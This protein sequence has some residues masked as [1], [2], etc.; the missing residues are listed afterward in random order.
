[1]LNNPLRYTDPSGFCDEEDHD[2]NCGVSFELTVTASSLL[3][4]KPPELPPR[5]EVAVEIPEYGTDDFSISFIWALV[6]FQTADGRSL[7]GVGTFRTSGGQTSATNTDAGENGSQNQSQGETTGGQVVGGG[8]AA[9]SQSLAALAATASAANRKAPTFEKDRFN[10][11]PSKARAIGTFGLSL[12]AEYAANNLEPGP[13]RGLA[14]T[15]AAGFAI[16]SMIETGI[17][18]GVSFLSIPPAIQSGIGALGVTSL[19]G[20]GGFF[21]Y[22]SYENYNN[23][24]G[25]T[26]DAFEDFLGPGL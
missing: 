5:S 8:G 2:E 13:L 14:N 10:L 26:T 24:V 12:V 3:T 25:F 23:A 15:A 6:Q 11:N 9:S 17:I 1:M 18:S 21:G 7:Y 16:V 20:T 22:L 19:P 4:I